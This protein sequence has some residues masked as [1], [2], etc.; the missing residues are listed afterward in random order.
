MRSGFTFVVSLQ[1]VSGRVPHADVHD[2][3][4][5]SDY[6]LRRGNTK[7]EKCPWSETAS[8]TIGA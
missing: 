3:G 7:G 2:V 8:A 5:T 1:S 4:K 6:V